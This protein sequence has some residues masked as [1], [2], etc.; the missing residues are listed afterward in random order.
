MMSNIQILKKEKC[1]GCAVCMNVCLKQS[2]S[3]EYDVEGFLYPSVDESSCT[4]CGI[5]TKKCPVLNLKSNANFSEINCYAGYYKSD[6]IINSTSGGIAQALYSQ[7]LSSGGIVYGVAYDSAFSKA[8]Y[9]R[10]EKESDLISILGTKYIQ[11]EKGTIYN[12][13]RKD[14]K[15]SKF[16]LF[17]GTPCEVA[18]LVS[19]LGSKNDNL[20][21]VELICHGPTSNHVHNKYLSE[22]NKKNLKINKFYVRYKDGKWLP[23]M[24]RC[25][26]ENGKFVQRKFDKSDYGIAFSLFSRISCHYCSFKGKNRYADITIGDFWGGNKNTKGYNELGTSVIFVHT[27]LGESMLVKCE[28]ISKEPADFDFAI[29]HN[30]YTYS[31]KPLPIERALFSKHIQSNSLKV[32]I[33]RSM[34]LRKRIKKRMP[35]KLKRILRIK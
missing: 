30:P 29:R 4:Q 3:M 31:S 2:I 17:V 20:L 13:V 18:A 34:S 7:C 21:L 5:C 14:L 27:L 33:K 1:T 23:K 6:K 28:S 15:D 32:S 19:F 12:D 25:E 35:Y 8:I 16:V 24:T 11:A 22:L 9:K 26:F 10:I